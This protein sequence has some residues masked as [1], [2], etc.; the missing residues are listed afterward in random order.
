MRAFHAAGQRCF[1][2]DIIGALEGFSEDADILANVAHLE[3][4][5]ALKRP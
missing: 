3:E 2:C 1:R 5:L 4:Q